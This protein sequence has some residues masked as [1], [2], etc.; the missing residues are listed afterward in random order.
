MTRKAMAMAT[1]AILPDDLER[2][3]VPC[4]RRRA[5][6]VRRPDAYEEFVPACCPDKETNVLTAR[7]RAVRG[8]YPVRLRVRIVLAAAGGRPTPRSPR[9]WVS[10]RIRWRRFAASRLT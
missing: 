10:A 1:T 6:L 3:G 8:P 2:R 5:G 4:C 7:A 9:T